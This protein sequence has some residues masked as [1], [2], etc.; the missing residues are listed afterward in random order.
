M[1]TQS[2]VSCI[3]F[4]L[5]LPVA[6]CGDEQST[7]SKA[8]EPVGSHEPQSGF[9]DLDK[10]AAHV[11]KPSEARGPFVGE[12]TPKTLSECMSRGKELAAKGDHVRARELFEAGA[13][14]DR[15][16]AD[17]VVELARSYIATGDK[18]LAVRHATKAVKL[19]PESSHAYNTL[20]RAELLRHDYDAAIVAF[21]QATE[22]DGDNVW[23]WNN[24]GLVYL[25]LKDYREAANALSEATS[26]K[27]VEGYMWNNLGLAYEQLDEL[28]DARDA[29]DEGAKL[30]SAVAKASRTRLEGVDTVVAVKS[31]KVE[32][33]SHTPGAKPEAKPETYELREPMPD[34]E[35]D[36][37]ELDDVELDDVEGDDV[38]ATEDDAEDHAEAELEPGDLE[39]DVQIDEAIID[40]PDDSEAPVVPPPTSL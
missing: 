7:P 23:A 25:T 3:L 26:R 22:L 31:S 34:V 27:G 35:L 17:P 39:I 33:S 37:V 11:V 5:L 13:R 16:H 12:L 21:R 1:K 19:A 2:Q 40:E 9:G 30:G 32:R 20:G 38:D 15:K 29:F 14:L 28:D 18:A 10:R 36:D 4:A 6:A 24:L 8:S